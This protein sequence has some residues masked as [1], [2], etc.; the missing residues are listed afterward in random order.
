MS[1]I[2]YSNPPITVTKLCGL[3]LAD[4]DPDRI[5]YQIYDLMTDTTI[6]M[7]ECEFRTMISASAFFLISPEA[8]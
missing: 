2:I 1:F 5:M 6:V 8:A 7:R 4:G 3:E